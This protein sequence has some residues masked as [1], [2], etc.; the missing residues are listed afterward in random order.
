MEHILASRTH[1]ENQRK[2]QKVCISIADLSQIGAANGRED[3]G[4]HRTFVFLQ[5]LRGTIKGL[6]GRCCWRRVSARHGLSIQEQGSARPPVLP[7]PG[8]VWLLASLQELAEEQKSGV[9]EHLPGTQGKSILI[10]DPPPPP[11]FERE[12]G[13]GSPLLVLYL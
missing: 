1:H 13:Y 5:I 7:L 3:P 11:G 9:L 2:L 4:C 10:P 6:R 8:R 12:G